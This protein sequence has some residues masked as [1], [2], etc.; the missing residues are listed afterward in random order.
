M[1]NKFNTKIAGLCRKAILKANYVL[2]NYNEVIWLIG[3]GRSGTTWVFDLINHDK[4]FREMFEPFH[5]EFVGD[6]DS[7]IPHQYIRQDD[8][9]ENLTDLATKIFSGMYTHPRVDSGNRSLLYKGLLIKDIFANLFS[10]WAVSQFPEVRPVLLIRNPFSVAISK[11]KKKNWF[12]ETEPLNL[13]SQHTLHEDYLTPFEDMIRRVSSG[14]DY[15]LNQILI[16]SII[17][18]VPLRQFSPGSIHICF[19]ENIYKE[20]VREIAKIYRFV[21]GEHDT[22]QLVIRNKII[23]RPSR[24]T[25][26]ESNLLSGTSPIS[27]WKNELKHKEID[28]GL[29][30]LQCFGFDN[31][32]DNNSMPNI[33]SLRNIHEFA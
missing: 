8:S 30:I 27:A 17:N 12:W 2:K 28:D 19:Y 13:L 15:I 21:R 18:Y 23:E 25:G 31:L 4:R 33:E 11:S 29:K 7:L 24:V 16:W 14:K 26:R 6:T 10:Y 32:Y 20:P 1:I 9:N 22:S 5:P 3:D